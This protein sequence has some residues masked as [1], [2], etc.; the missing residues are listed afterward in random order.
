MTTDKDEIE[1]T[2]SDSEEE[3]EEDSDS[4]SEEDRK[5]RQGSKIVKFYSD[6]MT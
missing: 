1:D 4:D 5:D 2:R 3:E 6:I